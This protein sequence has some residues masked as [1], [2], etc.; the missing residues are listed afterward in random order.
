[1]A[2]GHWVIELAQKSWG[3]LDD[4]EKSVFDDWLTT[5]SGRDLY[6]LVRHAMRPRKS[7]SVKTMKA[8]K[9]DANDD[10]QG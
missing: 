5:A 10:E 8:V 4:E 6:I 3:E 7:S 2:N 1:M 9:G